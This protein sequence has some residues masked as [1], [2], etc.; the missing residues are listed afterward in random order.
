VIAFVYLTLGMLIGE[1]QIVEINKS[2]IDEEYEEV[3]AVWMKERRID[4]KTSELTC[5][6]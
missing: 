4:Q 6:S 1:T 2:S 5:M 3:H